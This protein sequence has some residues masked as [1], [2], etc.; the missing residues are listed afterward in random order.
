LRASW[1]N[2][3]LSSG[4]NPKHLQSPQNNTNLSLSLSLALDIDSIVQHYSGH[5]SQRRSSRTASQPLD[6]TTTELRRPSTALPRPARLLRAAPVTFFS[7]RQV[8]RNIVLLRSSSCFLVRLQTF[9]RRLLYPL[10]RFRMTM[11]HLQKQQQ[12]MYVLL[13]LLLLTIYM[14]N[15]IQCRATCRYRNL[16]Q[17]AV[18][19]EW[20]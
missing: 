19:W 6:R 4:S 2:R 20:F 9:L 3:C 16:A 13:L 18:L 7:P 1:Q 15:V 5:S 17:E 10:L 14:F 11:L 8:S 12:Q